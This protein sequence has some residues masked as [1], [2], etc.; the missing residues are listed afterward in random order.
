[1]LAWDLG[2]GETAVLSYALAHPKWVV[3]LD[4]GG[5]RRCAR[6]LSLLITGT[7]AVVLVAK[8]YGLIASAAQVLH[9]LLGADFRLDDKTISGALERAEGK[10]GKQENKFHLAN[11]IMITIA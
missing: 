3:V 9:D 11:I 1:M 7:L 10:H 5:A 2:Q 6:S 4:D 8:L